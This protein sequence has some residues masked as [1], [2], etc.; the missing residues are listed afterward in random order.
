MYSFSTCF[1]PEGPLQWDL[2]KPVVDLAN[3]NLVPSPPLFILIDVPILRTGLQ[4]CMHTVC[5]LKRALSLQTKVKLKYR[6]KFLMNG[7]EVLE[8]GDVADFPY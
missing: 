4:D 3:V 2:L 1:D 6:L 7:S 8:S 5:T